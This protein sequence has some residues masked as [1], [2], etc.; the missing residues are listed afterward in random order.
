[1]GASTRQLAGFPLE[2]V[3]DG[4]L[5][6]PVLA[7]EG[8]DAFTTPCSFHD[9]LGFVVGQLGILLAASLD[10]RPACILPELPAHDQSSH[11]CGY[12]ELAPKGFVGGPG[13]C[14][15]A[16]LHD[17]CFGELRSW[18]VLAIAPVAKLVDGMGDVLLWRDDF[19]INQSIVRDVAVD[20]VGLHAWRDWTKEDKNDQS[21]DPL[22]DL[23][24]LAAGAQHHSEIPVFNWCLFEDRSTFLVVPI[25]VEPDT[26]EIGCGVRAVVPWDFS[27]L[28]FH[29]GIS[30]LDAYDTPYWRGC[31]E[32][33]N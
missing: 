33:E 27:P 11:G 18:V 7:C 26:T 3:V 12:A 16:E 25:N 29:G 5:G 19:K 32:K 17:L 23:T 2:P 6:E 4:S 28:F 9:G 21:I 14:Q 8:C 15:L 30:F 20:V 22:A 1:M 10:D 24:A 31:Q 13:V